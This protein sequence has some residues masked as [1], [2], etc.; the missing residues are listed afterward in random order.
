MFKGTSEFFYNCTNTQ[1]MSL[2]AHDTHQSYMLIIVTQFIPDP[3]CI[4][5]LAV[6]MTATMLPFISSRLGG[7]SR[8]N[9]R[10]LTY[11]H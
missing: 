1:F 9:T 3:L 5:L 4:L 6:E 10:F 2:K 11:P 8:T 7:R